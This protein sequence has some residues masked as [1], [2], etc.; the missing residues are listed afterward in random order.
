[1]RSVTGARNVEGYI[2]AVAVLCRAYR[3][4]RSIGQE[5]AVGPNAAPGADA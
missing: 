1:M 4:G 3:K 5:L 2:E